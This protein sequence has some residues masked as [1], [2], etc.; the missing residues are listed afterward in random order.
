MGNWNDIVFFNREITENGKFTPVNPLKQK[1]RFLQRKKRGTTI[2]VL[3][4]TKKPALQQYRMLKHGECPVHLM[5]SA[6]FHSDSLTKK[7][8]FAGPASQPATLRT[9]LTTCLTP[10]CRCV[11]ISLL[12]CTSEPLSFIKRFFW[13]LITDTE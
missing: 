1:K 13:G 9:S 12:Q 8:L 6:N 2:V 10:G 3:P 11:T 5:S 7:I 4:C